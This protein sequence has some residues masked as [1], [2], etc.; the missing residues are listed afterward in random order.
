MHSYI[1][2]VKTVCTVNDKKM[3]SFTYNINFYDQQPIV[4]TIYIE[5]PIKN[6]KPKSSQ[7]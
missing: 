4:V 3:S 5:N 7:K 6:F 1:D 2:V